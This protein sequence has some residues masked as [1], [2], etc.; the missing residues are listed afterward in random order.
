MS[1]VTDRKNS[2]S[3]LAASRAIGHLIVVERNCARI[4]KNFDAQ[5]ARNF[6]NQT[7]IYN[8]KKLSRNEEEFL[9]QS[10]D[11]GVALFRHNLLP[12]ELSEWAQNTFRIA[13]CANFFEFVEEIMKNSELFDCFV[14][15]TRASKM[16]IIS[17]I[18][19]YSVKNQKYKF[20]INE[21]EKILRHLELDGSL[22]Q[23]DMFLKFANYWCEQVNEKYVPFGLATFDAEKERVNYGNGRLPKTIYISWWMPLV[24]AIDLFLFTTC[25][26]WF[27]EKLDESDFQYSNSNF[28]LRRTSRAPLSNP[29][30]VPCDCLKPN[31]LIQASQ[32]SRQ[33]LLSLRLFCN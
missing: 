17:A 16:K 31:R 7:N 13:Q 11:F 24:T 25:D 9:C 21:N 27:K 5:I 1:L 18:E 10:F 33:L 30:K 22:H 20:S 32:I 8:I 28:L 19:Q 15:Q 29:F 6:S 14:F 26:V 2:Y 12:Y 23:K 4:Q 3:L